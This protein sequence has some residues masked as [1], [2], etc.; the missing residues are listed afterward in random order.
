MISHNQPKCKFSICR[1]KTKIFC[2]IIQLK[3][4]HGKFF[5]R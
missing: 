2:A 3:P 4:L 1:L 5:R